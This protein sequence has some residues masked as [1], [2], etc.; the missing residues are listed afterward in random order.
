MESELF[1]MVFN[2]G[3]PSAIAAYMII[4]MEK[5]LMGLT[6]AITTLKVYLEN[7]KI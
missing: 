5:T 7:K 2:Y 4:R 3:F 6:L 1:S